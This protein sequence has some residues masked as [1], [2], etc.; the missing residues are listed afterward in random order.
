[1]SQVTSR[2]EPKRNGK[3]QTPRTARAASDVNHAIAVIE[4]IAKGNLDIAFDN[5]KEANDPL[6]AA[7][8]QMVNRLVVS[9]GEILTSST[10]IDRSSTATNTT[11]KALRDNAVSMQKTIAAAVASTEEMRHNMNSVSASTEELS[12]NM[13]SIASAARQSNTNVDSVQVSIKELTTASR[14][15]AENT[16]RATTISKKAMADVTSALSLV[17]ELNDAARAIDAVTAT[18]SE[19]SDQT[20]LLALN[21]TIEAARAGEM[22]KGFAVVAKEVKDLA[23]QTNAATKGIQGKIGIIHEVARRTSDAIRAINDVMKEVNEAVTSIAAAA[24]EQSV[25]TDS[26]GQNVVSTTER[27]KEMS[28]NVSEGAVAV[29]DVSKS[30]LDVTNLSTSVAQSMGSL[31]RNALEVKADAAAS[32]AQALEVVSQGGDIKRT[33][34]AI[35][36]PAD[37]ANQGKNATLQLCRFTEDFDVMSTRMND[38]HRRIFAYINTVHQRV[39]DKSDPSTLLPTLKELGEFTRHHFQRE[40][41]AMQAANYEHLPQQRS[42]HEKLLGRVAQIIADLDK[43]ADVDMLEVMTFLKDWLTTHILVMDKEYGPTLRAHGIA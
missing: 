23:S 13:Q 29:Q 21:A 16:A 19:I 15:I 36:L 25:T 34:A 5:G 27:I 33:V 14:D 28:N 18:I 17:G 38:D 31:N 26:I 10:L 7:L 6:M 12:A 24:E 9:F 40:E 11:A 35:R 32:Y 22:G 43:G 37:V 20:K 3:A 42:A 30:I 4:E 1:M 2:T 8:R 41:E 39:K